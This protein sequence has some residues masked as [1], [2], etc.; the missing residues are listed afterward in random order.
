MIAGPGKNFSVFFGASL[1][2]SATG[3]CPVSVES[4]PCPLTPFFFVRPF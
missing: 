3:P 2:E 4:S 1:Q